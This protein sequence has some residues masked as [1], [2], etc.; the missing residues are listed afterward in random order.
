MKVLI[1]ANYNSGDYPSFVKEQVKDVIPLGVEIDYFGVKGK[2]VLGYLRNLKF[3]KSKIKA[4][5]PDIIHAHYGFCG[6][7]AN[8]QR[9]IPVITTYH[10]SDI[11]SRGFILCL[12]R[13]AI[14]M[15]A[16]NLFVGQHLVDILR[17][18]PEN[19]RVLPCGIDLDIVK[20]ICNVEARR[21]LGWDFKKKYILFSSTFSRTIKNYQLAR[22]SVDLAGDYELVE[23]K[24]YTREEV[25]LVMSAS[26]L[27]LMTSFREGSP[28]VIKEAMACNCPIVATNI[29]DIALLVD[30]VY[31]CF[32]TSFEPA[33]IAQKIN[34]VIIDGRRTNGRAKIELM[35][36]D[37]KNIAKELFRIYSIVMEKYRIKQI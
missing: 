34:Q 8:L 37:N 31:N 6:L 13:I 7:L 3:L 25:N 10:G 18:K 15:S 23:L 27:L 20:P 24:G 30:N 11:H 26:D 16:Y 32:V 21:Q 36:L 1:V 19:T 2:G 9:R 4:F 17:T 5:A 35:G 14:K 22:Q 29:A 28:M 12:S 33:E